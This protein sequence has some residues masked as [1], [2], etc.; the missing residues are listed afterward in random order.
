MP[1]VEHTTMVAAPFEAVW[2][3]VSDMD[4]WAP[5]V[6]GYQRHEK[7]S[8]AESIWMLKGELGGLTRIAEFRAL[9]T[10]WDERG[11]VRFTLQGINEPVCGEGCFIAESPDACLPGPLQ[12]NSTLR[13]LPRWMKLFRF[14]G[15]FF[16]AS[17]VASFAS[18]EATRM[19]FLLTLNAGGMAGPVLNMMMA[20]LLSPVAKELALGIAASIEGKSPK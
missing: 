4:N 11:R 14:L 5:L 20:P 13:S 12:R 15:T 18:T 6:T 19:S 2:S 10:E 1:S 8:E 9:V 7:I 17:P 3:F 16:S